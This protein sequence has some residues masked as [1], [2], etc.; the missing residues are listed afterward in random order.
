MNLVTPPDSVHPTGPRKPWEPPKI[1]E[2]SIGAVTAD[3]P[4][5]SGE[6]DG[7]SKSAS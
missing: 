7:G 4:G 1:E 6:C 5:F 3:K 2:S